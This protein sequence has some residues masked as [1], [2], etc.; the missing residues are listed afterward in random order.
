L[1]QRKRK[2]NSNRCLTKNS[3]NEDVS[4]FSKN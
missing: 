3:A 4:S 1:E 2:P